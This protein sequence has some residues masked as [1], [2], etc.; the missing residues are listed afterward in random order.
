MPAILLRVE[1]QCGRSRIHVDPADSVAS[2]AR[3]VAARLGL[4]D[5]PEIVRLSRGRDGDGMFDNPSASIGRAGMKHGDTVFA[6]IGS[7]S[8]ETLRD[9]EKHDHGEKGIKEGGASKADSGAS[10]A[11]SVSSSAAQT[12]LASKKGAMPGPTAVTT[13]VLHA[14][15]EATDEGQHCRKFI[16][17]SRIVPS[18]PTLA[19]RIVRRTNL[20]SSSSS[21]RS[22][23]LSTVRGPSHSDFTERTPLTDEAA[24]QY[25]SWNDYV[26]SRGGELMSTPR[27]ERTRLTRRGANVLPDT[28]TIKRQRFRHVD[29]VVLSNDTEFRQFAASWLASRRQHIGF[30]YGTYDTPSRGVSSVH[31]EAIYEP[32]QERGV[33]GVRLLGTDH[34]APIVKAIASLL[35]LE[36]VGW[37][38]THAP[39]EELL[40]CA[41]I[42]AAAQY[43]NACLVG[44][45]LGGQRSRFVT[46][47]LS[48]N[49]SGVI[50]PRAFMVSEQG[51]YFE[52]GGLMHATK[53]WPGY[54]SIR[55]PG[56]GFVFPIVLADTESV[57]Q[58]R[59]PRR[60]ARLDA[61]TSQEKPPQSFPIEL[62]L[63]DL[64][65][66]SAEEGRRSIFVTHSHTIIPAFPVENRGARQPSDSDKVALVHRYLKR[67]LSQ[68]PRPSLDV[69]LRRFHLLIMLPS[70]LGFDLTAKICRELTSGRLLTKHTRLLVEA[71]VREGSPHSV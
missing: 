58:M 9:E 1:S 32:P 63:V 62:V 39:R 44:N 8:S 42:R 20:S 68:S 7:A 40:T 56:K 50:C 36:P 28:I 52:M 34:D 12:Q 53:G 15:L 16:L 21:F 65:V 19:G 6:T 67:S 70:V 69:L 14:S 13:A 49:T 46:M 59:K 41:E 47:T 2:L 23:K 18:A 45:N 25:E 3:D 35:G 60:A 29:R 5:N 10:K 22:R 64:S 54:M 38:F 17:D 57:S 43:Q 71:F 11:E 31:V 37:M 48:T 26:A 55:N 4:D 61:S 33:S 27:L 66:A 51:M 30:L 24:Q